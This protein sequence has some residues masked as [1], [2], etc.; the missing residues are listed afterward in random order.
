MNAMGVSDFVIIAAVAAV[1]VLCVRR[2]ARPNRSEC[3]SCVSR[4]MC[5]SRFTGRC[6]AAD[7][8][9]K[10]ADD[11]LGKASDHE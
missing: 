4:G 2:L 5:T 11:A 9:V 1:F 8:M 7:H 6:H 3:A 10:R